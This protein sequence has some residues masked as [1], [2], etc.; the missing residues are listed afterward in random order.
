MDSPEVGGERRQP[1]RVPYAALMAERV[2]DLDF[3]I[4]LRDSAFG[5][6]SMFIGNDQRAPGLWWPTHTPDGL[7]TLHLTYAGGRNRVR[8]EAWGPGRQWLLEQT[9]G[10]LGVDDHPEQFRPPP[11]PVAD[12]L[13]RRRRPLR[14]GRTNR[15][16]EALL[17]SILGQKVQTQMAVRSL[18]ATVKRFGDPAPGPVRLT[19]F[20]A[21]ER[22]AGLGYHEFH[23][24]HVERKRADTIIR[25][26][27]AADRLEQVIDQTPAQADSRLRSIRGIGPWTSGW[28]R[29]I[30]LGDA[31]AIPIGDFHLPNTVAWALAGEERATDERMLE[32]LTPYEGHRGRVVRLVKTSGQ[33]APRYG[34]RLSFMEIGGY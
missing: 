32:L 15:V 11:G 4:D 25:A 27:R 24:F 13:A 14:F 3:D 6:K 9:P 5:H 16:F 21:A 20:P 28:V 29:W 2:V 18:R 1:R 33:A 30:A 31:D 19:T 8:A 23:R 12:L 34:H 26:A 7:G 10:L 22:I 17:P